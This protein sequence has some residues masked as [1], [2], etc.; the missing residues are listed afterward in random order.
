[1][2]ST[3]NGTSGAYFSGYWLPPKKTGP[4][5]AERIRR[6]L[7]GGRSIV[8]RG[9]LQREL[10]PSGQWTLADTEELNRT[11]NRMIRDGEVLEMRQEAPGADEFRAFVEWAYRLAPPKKARAGLELGEFFD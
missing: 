7:A 2:N 6:A 8:G 5:L 3:K 1:M 9:E 11:L 10:F 4:D